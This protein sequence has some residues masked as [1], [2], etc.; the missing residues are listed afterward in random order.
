MTELFRAEIATGLGL[1]LAGLSD[2][3]AD[4]LIHLVGG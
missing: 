2:A 4:F 1:V 3:V